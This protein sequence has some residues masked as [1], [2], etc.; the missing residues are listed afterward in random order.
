M[1]CDFGEPNTTRKRCACVCVC[2]RMREREIYI[3]NNE[4]R[5]KKNCPKMKRNRSR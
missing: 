2:D 4:D 1:R 3:Y 5:V